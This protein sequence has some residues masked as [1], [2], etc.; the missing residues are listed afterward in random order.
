MANPNLKKKDVAIIVLFFVLYGIGYA[1]LIEPKDK[2]WKKTEKDSIIP[3][4][5]SRQT[6]I[7]QPKSLS[8]NWPDTCEQYER[9]YDEPSYYQNHYDEYQDDPEDEVRFP[10]EIFDANDE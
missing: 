2:T 10:P 8:I 4:S 6:E 7:R 9:E 1:W 5:E 3:K